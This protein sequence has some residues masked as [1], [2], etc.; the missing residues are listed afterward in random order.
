[1]Q[2]VESRG[3]SE[4]FLLTSEAGRGLWAHVGTTHGQVLT[5]SLS[6]ARPANKEPRAHTTDAHTATP[7]LA[8]HLLCTP[9]VNYV[10]HGSHT[11]TELAPE[12]DTDTRPQ[13]AG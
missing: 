2:K 5:N 11:G 1:M 3:K 13:T 4:E 12:D 7:C 10:S 9:K 8:S 6:A